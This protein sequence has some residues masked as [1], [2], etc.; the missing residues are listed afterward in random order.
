[1]TSLGVGADKSH[2]ARSVVR[3][4]WQPLSGRSGLAESTGEQS[5]HDRCV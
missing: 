5:G 4:D 3:A 2:E 1:L